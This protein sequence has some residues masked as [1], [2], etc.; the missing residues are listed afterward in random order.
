M[1]VLRVGAFGMQTLGRPRRGDGSAGAG[2]G[3]SGGCGGGAGAGGDGAGR[4]VSPHGLLWLG[5]QAL[6]VPV[7]LSVAR[8]RF[9]VIPPFSVSCAVAC[10]SQSPENRE[11]PLWLLA[12][13]ESQ[14]YASFRWREEG[15]RSLEDEMDSGP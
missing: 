7:C 1:C 10:R 3:A 4:G 2:G 14:D 15:S 6:H 11:K 8:F 13:Q 12:G 9:V 5:H